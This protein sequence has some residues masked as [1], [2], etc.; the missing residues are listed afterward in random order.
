MT[1]LNQLATYFATGVIANRPATPNVAPNTI[2]FYYATDTLVL[3][4]W[5]GAA[6]V[7]A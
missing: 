5:T 3:Y 4:M 1:G 2:A 7:T 6:W